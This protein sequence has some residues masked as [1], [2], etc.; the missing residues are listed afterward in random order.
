MRRTSLLV[1]LA[2]AFVAVALAGLALV[3]LYVYRTTVGEF[4]TFMVA[5][6]RGDIVA[7]WA[8][9]YREHGSWQ[10][11]ELELVAPAPPRRPAALLRQPQASAGSCAAAWRGR[12]RRPVSSRGRAL[13]WGRPRRALVRDGVPIIVDGRGGPPAAR[14]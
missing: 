13:S 14:L 9:Y 8:E 3:A 12:R 5:H 1:K 6:N 7:R 10:G 11:V 4:S 2:I